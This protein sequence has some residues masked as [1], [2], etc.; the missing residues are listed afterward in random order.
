MYKFSL[1]T[2]NTH[3]YTFEALNPRF[4]IKQDVSQIRIPTY[5]YK[6]CPK[7]GFK[8]IPVVDTSSTNPTT[9]VII[10]KLSDFQSSCLVNFLC[11]GVN[12]HNSTL[13]YSKSLSS[14]GQP[15]MP[16]LSWWKR[17]T[18]GRNL[19]VPTL[20]HCLTGGTSREWGNE[21]AV[22]T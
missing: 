10:N 17:D 1:N 8:T 7:V 16:G 13:K 4:E 22:K 9:I 6:V 21:M 15:A 11:L 12:Y 5:S 3:Q 2:Q 18:T 14:G 19:R 20:A